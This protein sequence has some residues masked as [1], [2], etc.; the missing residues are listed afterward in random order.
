MIRAGTRAPEPVGFH[1]TANTDLAKYI[2]VFPRA[3]GGMDALFCGEVRRFDRPHVPR[4][5]MNLSDMIDYVEDG[6]RFVK[7]WYT[8]FLDVNFIPITVEV[9]MGTSPSAFATSHSIRTD[10]SLRSEYMRY[11]MY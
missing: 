11:L 2:F 3:R 7:N 9:Y 4:D 5:S 1:I 6:I 8:A 10:R